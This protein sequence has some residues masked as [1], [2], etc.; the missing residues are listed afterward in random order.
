M[1]A[2]AERERARE[3]PLSLNPK[4]QNPTPLN[5]STDPQAVPASASARV[6]TLNPK[7]IAVSPVNVREVQLY[8]LYLGLETSPRHVRV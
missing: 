2:T 8:V 6:E 7:P 5:P 4:P 3:N 1:D